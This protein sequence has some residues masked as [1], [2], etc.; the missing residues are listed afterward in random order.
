[1]K[2][3]LCIGLV[4]GGCLT[5]FSQTTDD[6]VARIEAPISQI[7]GLSYTVKKYF[8][9]NGTLSSELQWRENSRG[10]YHYSYQG[11]LPT[12]ELNFTSERSFSPK[13]G[14]MDL[15]PLD[16]YLYIYPDD[17]S[18]PSEILNM[19]L[20]TSAWDALGAVISDKFWESPQL[21]ILKNNELKTKMKF[22]VLGER[23][24]DGKKCVA[25][26]TKSARSRLYN[27]QAVNYETF[28]EM[29]SGMPIAW[30]EKDLEGNVLTKLTIKEVQN[31]SIAGGS[32]DFP[33]KIRVE[34]FLPS[35][36]KSTGTP[37]SIVDFEYSDL[38]L[39]EV[40]EEDMAIDVSRVETIYDTASKTVITVPK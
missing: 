20:M 25:I 35:V 2:N 15:L 3:F 36:S 22:A 9:H 23:E 31:V 4:W 6:L 24:Y 38:K 34:H 10:E 19:V 14:H 29:K 28:I 26:E 1:M 12:G 30:T 33:R 7:Q 37:S 21:S 11:Y 18:M 8:A 39:N 17:R 27:G 13:F 5:S 40:S 32:I 16:S